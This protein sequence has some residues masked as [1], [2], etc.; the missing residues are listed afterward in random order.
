M[1]EDNKK[2]WFGRFKR[3]SVDT[4]TRQQQTA[5]PEAPQGGWLQ[6]LKKGLSRSSNALTESISGIFTKR[7]LDAETLE[8]LEDALIMADLGVE[9]AAKMAQRIAKD[10]FGKEVSDQEI[11]EALAKE[12]SASL[13]QAAKP[14]PQR[15]ELSPQVI[16][17]A[18]VN[19]VGKTTTIGKLAKQQMLAGRKVMMAAC[20]TFRAAAVEQLEIWGERNGCP[21]MKAKTG[22]DPSRARL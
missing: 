15:S 18:G 3:S 2:G 19:G 21:V 6:R 14:L 7:K 17:V 5:E 8:E 22:S 11:K 10:R 4:L 9:A 20:D 13:E 12:I 16:L 1:S